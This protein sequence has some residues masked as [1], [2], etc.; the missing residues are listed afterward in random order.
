[1]GRKKSKNGGVIVSISLP[2]LNVFPRK[3]KIRDR[4]VA[5]GAPKKKKKERDVQSR[6]STMDFC[7]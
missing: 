6:V 7:K 4:R 5:M 3:K 1:L 2:S